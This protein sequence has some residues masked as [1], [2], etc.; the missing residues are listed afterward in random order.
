MSAADDTRWSVPQHYAT[1]T[2]HRAFGVPG[3]P[4]GEA[5]AIMIA[6][7]LADIRDQPTSLMNRF[8]WAHLVQ[9]FPQI[10]ELVGEFAPIEPPEPEAPFWRSRDIEDRML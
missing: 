3:R 1:E 2:G 6:Q 4:R 7:R 8:L 10:A 5:A 9:H